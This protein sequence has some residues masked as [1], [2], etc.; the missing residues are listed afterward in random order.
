LDSSGQEAGGDR[1]DPRKQL[2]R[3]AQ[4]GGLL[5]VLIALLTYL[6][7]SPGALIDQHKM[8]LPFIAIGVFLAAEGTFARWWYLK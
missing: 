4:V 2:G 8:A 5:A 1:I 7:A 3:K 6:A